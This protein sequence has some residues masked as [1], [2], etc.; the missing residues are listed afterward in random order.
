MLQAVRKFI[1]LLVVVALITVGLV[2]IVQGATNG[3]M[4]GLVGQDVVSQIAVTPPV[5]GVHGGVVTI[6]V[7]LE[8]AENCH[9]VLL[10]QQGFAVVYPHNVSN[11]CSLSYSPKVRIGV[12]PTP[13]QTRI[14]TFNLVVNG[15]GEHVV[16][17]VEI[18]VQGTARTPFLTNAGAENWSGY[19]VQGGPFTHVAATFVVPKGAVGNCS[20]Y[21]SQWVGI[22]GYSNSDLIQAGIAEQ[23]INPSPA[24]SSSTAC[25]ELYTN[26]WW[27]IL[28]GAEVPINMAVKPGDVITV[29]ITEVSHNHWSI[30]IVNETTGARFYH[31]FDYAGPATSAEWVMESPT[32]AG[33]IAALLPYTTA[34]FEDLQLTG[35]VLEY[36]DVWLLFGPQD[37]RSVPQVVKSFAALM[38]DGFTVVY[39]G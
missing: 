5:V 9:L 35:T 23:D 28:P 36:S 19:A 20:A 18:G 11:N 16:I 8:G 7:S 10:S 4:S 14:V 38:A 2:P 21:L 26:V 3:P 37:I 34:S 22:D 30:S 29:A 31:V 24:T 6:N 13:D 15:L 33:Q 39:T 17:P 27:E 25:S 12:N 1:V 32:I